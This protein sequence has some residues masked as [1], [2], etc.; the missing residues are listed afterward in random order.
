MRPRHFSALLA[1]VFTLLASAALAGPW[2]PAPG[3]YYTEFRAGRVA[4]DMLYDDGGSAS[5]IAGGG[6]LEERRLISTTELGWKENVSFL[7]QVPAVSM[8]YRQRTPDTESTETGL[9]DMVI[10]LRYR[11]VEGATALA[12][13]GDWK[14]PLG[15]DRR[16]DPTLGDGQQDVMG[17]VVFGAPLSGMG[18]VQLGGGYRYRFES[19]PDEVFGSADVAIFAGDA[20]LVS[21]HY[22]GVISMASTDHPELERNL[23]TAGPQVLLRVD[24]AL[25]LFAG[26]RFAIAG[27]NT[28]QTN[29]FYIGVAFKQTQLGR[30]QGFLG[31]GS[32]P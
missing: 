6:E 24:D 20:F 14:A 22:D 29:E 28:V 23:H 32:R 21:G 31:S 15:Y 2:L 10:G 3:D 1:A 11:L 30:L 13:E 27:K 7:L 18:F 5:G 26:S 8:T 25:D 17:Q 12:I 4:G 9:G 19:P 16:A